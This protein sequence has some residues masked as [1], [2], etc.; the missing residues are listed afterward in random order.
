MFWDHNI[1][2]CDQLISCVVRISVE[3]GTIK[4]ILKQN[5]Q[6]KWVWYI[7]VVKYIT[8]ICRSVDISRDFFLEVRFVQIMLL[9]NSNDSRMLRG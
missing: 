9:N 3:R 7:I 5:Q 2:F 4:G 1:L 6:T 8:S